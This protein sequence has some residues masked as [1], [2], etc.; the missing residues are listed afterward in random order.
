VQA[1]AQDLRQRKKLATRDAL[2]EAA[3]RLFSQ[4]GYA[5]T[6]V[7]EIAAAADVSRSTFF[8]YFGSKEAVI[9]S[10]PDEIGERFLNLIADRP[11]AEGP[12]KAIEEA[13]VALNADS[14][15]LTKGGVAVDRESLFATEPALKARQAEML[16]VWTA[17]IADALAAREGDPVPRTR[18]R[19]AAAICLAMSQEMVEEWLNSPL[20]AAG[21]VRGRFDA[22]RDLVGT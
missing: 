2:H 1:I 9:F 6:S 12:L 4:K 15:L 7:D 5:A 18:H 20:D 11:L 17:R 13:L 19:L 10:V 3:V 21:L 8:R 22:L 16:V 14:D